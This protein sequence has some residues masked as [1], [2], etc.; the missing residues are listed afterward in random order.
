MEKHLQVPR[1]TDISDIGVYGQ[2]FNTNTDSV[3]R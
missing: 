3:Y 2:V 1:H